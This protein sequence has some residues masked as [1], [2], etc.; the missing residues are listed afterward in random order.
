MDRCGVAERRG[1]AVIATLRSESQSQRGESGA[2]SMLAIG[3]LASSTRP[4]WVL[5]G[6]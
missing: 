4:V 6:C 3:V 5:G 1:K 2:V